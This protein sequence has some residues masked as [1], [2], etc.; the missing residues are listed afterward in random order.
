MKHVL[1]TRL[2]RVAM[3]ATLALPTLVMA[4]NGYQ[5]IGVG[6]YQKSLGGAVTA[7]PGS[8]MTSITNPA[9]MARIGNRTDFSIEA[10]MPDRSTDFG[11]L[12]DDE[13]STD[14]EF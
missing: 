12:S 6:S 11:D 14:S 2:V 8:A 3:L 4:T 10:I 5:L 1:N 9:G 7:N 13:V